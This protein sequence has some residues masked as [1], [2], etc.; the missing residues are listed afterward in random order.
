[1][2]FTPPFSLP[3]G[4]RDVVRIDTLF[5]TMRDEYTASMKWSAVTAALYQSAFAFLLPAAVR[6]CLPES[7]TPEVIEP[8]W[9]RAMTAASPSRAT[10][11]RAAWVQFVIY[12]R[13]NGHNVAAGVECE[14]LVKPVRRRN[15]GGVEPEWGIEQHDGGIRVLR[16]LGVPVRVAALLEWSAI[17]AL[18]DETMVRGPRGRAWIAPTLDVGEAIDEHCAATGGSRTGAFFRVRS[19]SDLPYPTALIVGRWNRA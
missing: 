5:D 1:M 8:L 11:V 17:E 2:D 4:S 18:G 15:P 12:A 7:I 10:Q 13:E 6:A 9:R 19:D 16:A 3:F 14:R